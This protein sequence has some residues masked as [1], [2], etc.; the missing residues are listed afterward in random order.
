M[1]RL[2]LLTH[3]RTQK[4]KLSRQ[5]SPLF[6]RSANAAMRDR[7]RFQSSLVAQLHR[8]IDQLLPM[9]G[10]MDTSIYLC[11]CHRAATASISYSC[12]HFPG[13]IR[14]IRC[15]VCVWCAVGVGINVITIHCV[16]CVIDH[17]N[18]IFHSAPSAS[19]SCRI[20]HPYIYITI[21]LLSIN[22]CH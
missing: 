18:Q 5:L 1:A 15:T 21:Y 20:D 19:H 10:R 13:L 12:R 2:A 3:T 4:G 6:D 22:L 8:S 9:D 17:G 7:Y 11:Q 16:V 14:S